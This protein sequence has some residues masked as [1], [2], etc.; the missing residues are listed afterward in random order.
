MAKRITPEQKSALL[1]GLKVFIWAGLS[2][3]VP[4]IVATIEQDTR[5]A[6]FAPV[7][8]AIAYGLKIKFGK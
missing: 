3:V 5:W 4:L 6:M 8:N 2:A 7:I 1:E